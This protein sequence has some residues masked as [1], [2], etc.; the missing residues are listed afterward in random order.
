MMGQKG[1]AGLAKKAQA[2]ALSRNLRSHR[3]YVIVAL[4]LALSPC[5]GV[6]LPQHSICSRLRL[7]LVGFEYCAFLRPAFVGVVKAVEPLPQ[8]SLHNMLNIFQYSVS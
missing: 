3:A 5:C 6:V 8:Q 7:N 1:L 4:A 2:Q